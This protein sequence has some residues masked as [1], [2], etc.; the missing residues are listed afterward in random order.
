MGNISADGVLS[1]NVSEYEKSINRSPTDFVE[2]LNCKLLPL[3]GSGCSIRALNTKGIPH[4]SFCEVTYESVERRVATY[5][6]AETLGL[7][8]DNA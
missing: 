5:I 1:L 8:I 3:C 6:R 2:C 4:R 7:L